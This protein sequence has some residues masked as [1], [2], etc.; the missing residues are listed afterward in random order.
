M[1]D[2]IYL[3]DLPPWS[4][5]DAHAILLDTCKKHKVDAELFAELV[6]LQRKYQNMERARGIYEDFDYVFE[7]MK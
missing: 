5:E 7:R 4:D 2:E 6:A 1:D 3:G